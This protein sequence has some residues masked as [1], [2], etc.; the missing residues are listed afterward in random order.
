VRSYE[1]NERYYSVLGGVHHTEKD[2]PRGRLIPDDFR[3]AGTGGLS[4]CPA[5][6]ERI[7][8][9]QQRIAKQREREGKALPEE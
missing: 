1:D 8:A 7:E 9:D 3:R 5:C 4:L 6:R 2:C